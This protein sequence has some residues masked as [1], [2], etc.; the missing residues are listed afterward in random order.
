MNDG[1]ATDTLLVLAAHM[2]V[3]GPIFHQGDGKTCHG[4]VVRELTPTEIKALAR[5]DQHRLRAVV[6]RGLL[7]PTPLTIAHVQDF[8]E[9]HFDVVRLRKN[10]KS[11]IVETRPA[12]F[13]AELATLRRHQVAGATTAEGDR[14]HAHPEA[15]R[16]HHCRARLRRRHRVV[17]DGGR[18]TSATRAGS[19]DTRG[20]D[21]SIRDAGG[22]CRR[23]PV[24]D[25]RRQDRGYLLPHDPGAPVLIRP[26]PRCLSPTST[27]QD[28]QGITLLA[29]RPGSRA[30][31]RP[32]SLRCPIAWKNSRSAWARRCYGCAMPDLRA[33]S[34]ASCDLTDLTA[35]LTQGGC[36]IRPRH[37]RR[38]ALCSEWQCHDGEWE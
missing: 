20:C 23:A 31:I 16:H 37:D 35:Y 7:M 22:T 5:N 14:L 24:R 33:T 26:A 27:G 30:A 25:R 29:P 32:S 38:R 19:T 34:T 1:H 12:D 28:R 21:G 8:A 36:V 9:R 10:P 13:R 18:H 17:A 15:G 2:A 4:V 3:E 11:T 6:P